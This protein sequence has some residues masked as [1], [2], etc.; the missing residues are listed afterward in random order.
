MAA[1]LAGILMR[2][3]PTNSLWR[4]LVMAIVAV[5]PAVGRAAL[6]LRGL[7]VSDNVLQLSFCDAD[8]RQ[9]Y[10]WKRIGE[11]VDGFKITAYDLKTETATLEKEKRNLL[12]KLQA[13]VLLKSAPENPKA[14]RGTL[15]AKGKG[16]RSVTLAAELTFG[17]ETT[18]D[19]GNNRTLMINPSKLPDGNILYLVSFVDHGA[20]EP[21][22]VIS[23]PSE[24]SPPDQAFGL[25]VEG[26]E[27]QFSP[28][29]R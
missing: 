22:K 8:T 10:G 3:T 9:S 4:W 1:G 24:V 15:T 20:G 6:E 18:I 19:L 12:L 7:C 16:G 27:L 23:M 13:G 2:K 26:D 14:I 17:A 29:A 25:W 28:V 5:F 21:A 11:S